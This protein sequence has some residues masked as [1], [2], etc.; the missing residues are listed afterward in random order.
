MR[1][2]TCSAD[3]ATGSEPAMAENKTQKTDADVNE[4]LS[5]IG[6]SQQRS[7]SFE[8]VRMMESATG[9]KAQMWGPSIIGFGETHLRY[10]S[11]R[12]LD[13]FKVG[14]SPRKSN[15]SLYLRLGE[16]ALKKLGKHSTG[17][18]CIYIKRLDDI[19]REVLASLID[20]AA[21]ST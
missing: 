2:P 15:L 19:D 11:G 21:K 16:K 12:E 17:K 10:E 3:S 4:F 9:A 1:L 5:N 20:Q 8:I 14:F 13:W 6:D 7:D 18:G